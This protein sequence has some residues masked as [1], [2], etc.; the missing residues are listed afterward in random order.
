MSWASTKLVMHKRQTLACLSAPCCASTLFRKTCA[1][2]AQTQGV[3]S[4]LTTD[5]ATAPPCTHVIAC[6]YTHATPRQQC[7][8]ATVSKSDAGSHGALT[9]LLTGIADPHLSCVHALPAADQRGGQALWCSPHYIHRT[10]QG[11]ES[12]QAG[13]RRPR[14]PQ[15][16]EDNQ[17][18]LP[19]QCT[20]DRQG[21][22]GKR[23]H[24]Q[25]HCVPHAQDAG[26]LWEAVKTHVRGHQWDGMLAGAP[27]AGQQ[28]PGL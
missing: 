6:A 24:Q 10:L 27:A 19:G 7:T 20:R 4:T 28:G 22:L 23:R 13:G 14:V 12:S 25:R 8:S 16:M 18:R 21:G 9:Q 26:H 2:P 5:L 1:G 17:R 15:A 11:P 3:C